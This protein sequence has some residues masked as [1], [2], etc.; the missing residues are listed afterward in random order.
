MGNY[1]PQTSGETQ[2]KDV[3]EPEQ[4]PKESGHDHDPKLLEQHS[5]TVQFL[6]SPV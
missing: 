5:Q 2:E 1:L 3:G 4:A 6:G